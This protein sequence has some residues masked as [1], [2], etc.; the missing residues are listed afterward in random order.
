MLKVILTLLLHSG[1]MHYVIYSTVKL[2]KIKLTF[3]IN[4]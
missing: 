4:V 1:K 2:F 3:Q